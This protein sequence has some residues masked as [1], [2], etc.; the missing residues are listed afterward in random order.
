MCIVKFLVKDMQK[1]AKILCRLT[2][3]CKTKALSGALRV[4][5]W[6]EGFGKAQEIVVCQ[7]CFRNLRNR[8]RREYFGLIYQE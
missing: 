5:E 8:N 1:P 2:V 7:Y 4:Y 3:L 6:Y